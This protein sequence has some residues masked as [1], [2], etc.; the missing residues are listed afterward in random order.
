MKTI[1]KPPINIIGGKTIKCGVFVNKDNKI[2]Q[3]SSKNA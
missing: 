2:E 3:L 1:Q